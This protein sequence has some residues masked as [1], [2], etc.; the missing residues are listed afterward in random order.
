MPNTIRRIKNRT[1][2]FSII[3]NGCI[4]NESLSWRARGI[5]AYLL[6][7]PDDWKIYKKE[8]E[9]RAPDGRESLAAGFKELMDAGYIKAERVID[10][11]G[12]FAGY[13]YTVDEEPHTAL[14]YTVLPETVLPDTVNPHLLSTNTKQSTNST[15]DPA[16]KRIQKTPKPENL[17]QP[18]PE[19]TQEKRFQRPTAEEVKA[20]CDERKNNIDPQAFVDY[21]EA[22][23]WRTGNSRIKD[24]RACVRTWEAHERK[25][26]A[27]RP[28]SAPRPE[29]EKM[30]ELSAL[31]LD[32]RAK[33]MQRYYN[34]E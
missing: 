34:K 17:L 1:K 14:P 32:A 13:D 30:P 25:R 7:M 8:L 26:N 6:S 23:D 5:L 33:I 9:K 24:W 2:G 3:D 11:G 29:P 15:K 4:Q 31:D 18:T 21:Y 22:R 20:Y 19:P 12:R 16:A 10:E 27:S 28:A